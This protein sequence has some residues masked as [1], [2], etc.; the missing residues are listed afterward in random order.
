[1][2]DSYTELGTTGLDSTDYRTFQSSKKLQCWFIWWNDFPKVMHL[3]SELKIW[4][5]A[6]WFQL[7]CYKASV[8]VQ[9]HEQVCSRAPH[10]HTHSDRNILS[11]RTDKQNNL[12]KM[13]MKADFS[14]LD[15]AAVKVNILKIK[16]KNFF[17]LP[18]AFR[19]S[20]AR[21]P[22]RTTAATHTAAVTTLGP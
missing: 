22:T 8:W 4:S 17:A 5:Q 21:D 15:G 12:N 16:K 2:T 19:S 11:L 13:D 1:M 9:I 6:T 18:T 10:T 14:L 3:V 7:T 20:P